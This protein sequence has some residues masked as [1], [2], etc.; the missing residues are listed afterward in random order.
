[1]S[2]SWRERAAC[3]TAEPD[4]FFP[5]AAKGGPESDAARARAM[6]RSCPVCAACLSFA[7]STSQAYGIWGGFS[8][9]ERRRLT[10]NTRRRADE[11]D[12]L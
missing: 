3:R 2:V 4:M 8:E 6:C 7:L 5:A 12:W 9:G 1:M 11:Q 10:G